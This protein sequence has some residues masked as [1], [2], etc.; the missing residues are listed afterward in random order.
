MSDVGY[1]IE[2]DVNFSSTSDII[3]MGANASAHHGLQRG[4]GRE[5]KFKFTKWGAMMGELTRFSL[6]ESIFNILLLLLQWNPIDERKKAVHYSLDLSTRL[7]SRF[8]M[9][10]G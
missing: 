4:G 5:V 3:S 1:K 2:R 10:D 8:S 9:I 6:I 7:V